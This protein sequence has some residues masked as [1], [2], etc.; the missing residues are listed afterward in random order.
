MPPPANGGEPSS[1]IFDTSVVNLNEIRVP[2]NFILVEMFYGKFPSDPSFPGINWNLGLRF[3]GHVDAEQRPK[4]RAQNTYINI[5]TP[6]TTRQWPILPLL[7]Q[8]NRLLNMNH[9]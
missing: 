6:Q 5:N 7:H 9:S 3:A 1:D 2:M 4:L 8:Q